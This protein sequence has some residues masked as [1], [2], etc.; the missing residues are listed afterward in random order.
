MSTFKFFLVGYN[1]AD[2]VMEVIGVVFDDICNTP[3]EVGSLP[4]PWGCVN[5]LRVSL[6][7]GLV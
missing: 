2:N 5:S 6:V 3:V 4:V 7:Y 1:S